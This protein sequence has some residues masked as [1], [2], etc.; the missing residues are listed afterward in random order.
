[1]LMFVILN[2]NITS[3]DAATGSGLVQ[4]EDNSYIITVNTE[5][6]E[7]NNRFI[8]F[9]R[10]G[11]GGWENVDSALISGEN[12]VFRGNMQAPEVMYLRLK[13]SDKSIAFFAENSTIYILPDFENPENTVVKG[14]ESHSE[15]ENYLGMMNTFEQ[16]K[17]DLYA[18]YN[19]ARAA[20][21]SLEVNSIIVR[22]DAL[23]AETMENN[24]EF[25]NTHKASWVSPYIIRRNSYSLSLEELQKLVGI[26]DSRLDRSVYVKDLKEHIATLERVAIG[27]KFTDFSLPTPVGG[28]LSLSEVSQNNYILIDFWASW[29]GPCRRENPNVVA[30]YNDFHE[31]GFDILGVSLDNSEANWKKAIED[32]GLVWHH[33]SDLKGWGSAAGKLYGVNSIPHTV[34]LDKDG[35]IIAKNLRGEELR[36][37]LEELLD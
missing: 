35:V 4:K 30:L 17:K 6:T 3:L 23:E 33:V 34:L 24:K 37:K 9:S 21:D 25:V 19:K 11:S 28:S 8:Y 10:R 13:H 18:A 14:S 26:L 31:K 29:C 12:V 1:M 5:A 20:N 36:E 15:Y 2:M 16:Q 32:D 27:Q 22:F 7:L